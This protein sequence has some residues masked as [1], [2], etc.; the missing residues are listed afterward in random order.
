M[1]P[2][3]QSH[4]HKGSYI[5]RIAGKAA[6]YVARLICVAALIWFGLIVSQSISDTPRITEQFAAETTDKSIQSAENIFCLEPGHWNFNGSNLAI[7]RHNCDD[8]QAKE[9]LDHFPGTGSF[10]S[11]C[12]DA[13]HLVALAKLN[14]ATQSQHESGVLW[15]A[16]DA[17]S[18]MRLLV[19]DSATP[20][21]LAVAVATKLN[22]RW[23]V[24]IT[25]SKEKANGYLLP[26]PAKTDVACSRRN[27]A[28]EIQM[29]L[30]ET[31]L[32]REQLLNQWRE[33]GWE[34]RHTQWGSADSFSYLCVKNEQV[35]YAWSNV[36]RGKKTLLL[37]SAT[38]S[39]TSSQFKQQQLLG[40][41][42]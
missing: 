3:P 37:S 41:R 9:Y 21:L 13:V 15:T 12:G 11:D 10:E 39:N 25:N 23:D 31:S 22:G 40:S 27:E 35:V 29:Q 6:D 14:G 24:T 19:T 30:L 4:S 34:I 2:S 7:G 18:R 42:R 38:T 20:K 32:D 26:M 5:S 17:E 33:S 16:D 8:R 1:M 28:G 36:D